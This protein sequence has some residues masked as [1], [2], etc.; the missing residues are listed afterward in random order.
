MSTKG[1]QQMF[2]FTDHE[3]VKRQHKGMP[4][5]LST[6]YSIVSNSISIDLKIV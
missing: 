5:I 2:C 3:V 1:E 4:L 6:L